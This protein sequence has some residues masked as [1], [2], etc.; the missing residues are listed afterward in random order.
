MEDILKTITEFTDK[1]H[2][3]QMRK[4]APDRYIVHPV[5]VMNLCRN[6]TNDLTVLAAALM[7]DVLEDTPVTKEEI[8]EF[9][10]TGMDAS[11]AD[12]TVALVVELTDVYVKADYP[13]L[14]R[15]TRKAK[16]RDRIATTSGEAQTIKYADIID[17]CK[18]IVGEDPDFADVFLRECHQLLQRMEAGN[19]ELRQIAFDTVARGRAVLRQQKNV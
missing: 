15:R 1:A 7:H 17:N 9:L 11:A 14:N 13:K 10:L 6:Y 19:A 12:R 16:E 18:E 3:T 4:Y 8:R 2:G 5:R